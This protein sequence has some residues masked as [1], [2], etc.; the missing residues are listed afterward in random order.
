MVVGTIVKSGVI[1]QLIM[2]PGPI[3]WWY[4]MMHPMLTMCLNRLRSPRFGQQRPACHVFGPAIWFQDGSGVFAATAA[5]RKSRVLKLILC[6]Q[7]WSYCGNNMVRIIPIWKAWQRQIL[8]MDI[9]GCFQ[10]KRI[11][12]LQ[13]AG[14]SWMFMSNDVS[15]PDGEWVFPL[16]FWDLWKHPTVV[17]RFAL[18]WIKHPMEIMSV[19]GEVLLS[20]AWIST[21]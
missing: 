19:F 17:Q 7:R 2:F 4:I 9:Q 6:V 3:W 1:K 8:S 20:S 13:Y 14:C 16:L 18:L 21:L 12:I 15:L 5:C 11:Q 10:R